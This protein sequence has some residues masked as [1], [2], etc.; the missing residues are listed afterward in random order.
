MVSFSAT[1]LQR[2]VTGSN[3]IINEEKELDF[4]TEADAIDLQE[5]NMLGAFVVTDF[6]SGEPKFDPD[7]LFWEAHFVTS[8]GMATGEVK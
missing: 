7:Y 6:Y 3:P 8:T 1:R 4:Y 5:L 2:L